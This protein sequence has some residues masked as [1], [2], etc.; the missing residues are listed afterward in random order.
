MIRL[1][2]RVAQSALP[3]N[4][5]TGEEQIMAPATTPENKTDSKPTPPAPPSPPAEATVKPPTSD[6]E[7]AGQGPADPSTAS[8]EGAETKPK[9]VK[10]EIPEG[11][12]SPVQFAKEIDKHL[13][14]PEGTTPPQQVYGYINNNKAFKDDVVTER[15][16]LPKF[17][18][19][20]EAGLAWLDA[21]ESRRAD[22]E[23]A[24]AEKAKAADEAMKADTAP[25]DPEVAGEG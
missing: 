6:Q 20:L 22:R 21:K 13:K 1:Q 17:I 24:K 25:T 11:F 2:D 14:R 4:T 15:D 5:Q 3:N 16:G 19:N 10:T 7:A 12:V 9:Q 23:K 8:G 18:V